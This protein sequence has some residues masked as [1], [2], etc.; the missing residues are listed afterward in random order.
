MGMRRSGV[1][2]KYSETE[3]NEIIGYVNSGV[4]NLDDI[5]SVLFN[6]PRAERINPTYSEIPVNSMPTMI[7]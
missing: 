4:K 2:S 3:F 7:M 6:M 5:T 1:L